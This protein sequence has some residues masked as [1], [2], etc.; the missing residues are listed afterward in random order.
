MFCN[1]GKGKPL[2][3]CSNQTSA[4]TFLIASDI[5]QRKASSRTLRVGPIGLSALFYLMLLSIFFGFLNGNCFTYIVV[6]G[7]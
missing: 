4:S 1:F 2:T 7:L 6:G 5:L 3:I